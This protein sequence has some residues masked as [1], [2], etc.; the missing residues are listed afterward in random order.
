MYDNKNDYWNM[1]ALRSSKEMRAALQGADG[2]RTLTS[3]S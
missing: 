3:K 1:S 2:K